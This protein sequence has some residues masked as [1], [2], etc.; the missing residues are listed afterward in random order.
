MEPILDIPAR[1]ERRRKAMTLAEFADDL[2]LSPKT[3]YELV[4]KDYIPCYRIAGSIR[5]DPVRIAVW[6]HL[7]AAA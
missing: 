6:L 7:Q 2:N 1:L 5:F 4:S 3:I